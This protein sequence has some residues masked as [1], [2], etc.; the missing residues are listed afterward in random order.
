MEPVLP[1]GLYRNV[2]LGVY[3]VLFVPIRRGWVSTSWLAQRYCV[4]VLISTNLVLTVWTED[5][6]SSR[7]TL[8]KPLEFRPSLGCLIEYLVRVQAV[9]RCRGIPSSVGAEIA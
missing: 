6:R 5:F 8:A 2:L 4:L 3:E 1:A 9:H 7:R